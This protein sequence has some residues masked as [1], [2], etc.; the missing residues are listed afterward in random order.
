[1][2]SN[3]PCLF[4]QATFVNHNDDGN[5]TGNTA[6]LHD[7]P[8]GF[9]P[10]FRFND[11]TGEIRA[12]G[13]TVWLTEREA[14]VFVTLLQNPGQVV[15][16]G[17]LLEAIW[18]TQD[19]EDHHAIQVY[20]S[21]IRSK[22]RELDGDASWIRS[23]RR[24]GYVFHQQ[25]ATL[26]RLTYDADLVVTDI[27]PDDRFFLGWNPAQIIGR[28]FL[29]AD[30]QIPYDDQEQATEA[31]RT[32][33]SLGILDSDNTLR[34]RTGDGDFRTHRVRMRSLG[35][36]DDFQGLEATIHL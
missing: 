35:P 36:K 19:V 14:Q 5:P 4:R 7:S 10:P 25:D 15:D 12:N 34:L 1:V 22:T 26:V 2:A 17:S 33:H 6:M 28:F 11:E 13:K 9:D 20:V 21:R 3:K 23:I 16:H 27:D 18:G 8:D 32:L 24:R 29:L 31:V 30:G